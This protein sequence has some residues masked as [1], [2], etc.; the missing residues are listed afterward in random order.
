MEI[1]AWHNGFMIVFRSPQGPS[2]NS[3]VTWNMDF[4]H[5]EQYPRTIPPNHTP[6]HTPESYLRTI[7][8]DKHPVVGF[9]ILRGTLL[10]LPRTWKNVGYSWP[11]VSKLWCPTSICAPVTCTWRILKSSS[12]SSTSLWIILIPVCLLSSSTCLRIRRLRK[13][14]GACWRG[15]VL[16]VLAFPEHFRA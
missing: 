2:H 1:H 16:P 13:T 4:P 12:I 6:N 3:F 10:Q 15:Q 14:S 11:R 8:L 7:P 5:P 9:P